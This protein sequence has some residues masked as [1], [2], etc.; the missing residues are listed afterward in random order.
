M[1]RTIEIG[2]GLSADDRII[3]SPQDGIAS[4]DEV[5]I[6]STPAAAPATVAKDQRRPPG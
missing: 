4:G 6:A 2:S 1:G 3:A 5:R